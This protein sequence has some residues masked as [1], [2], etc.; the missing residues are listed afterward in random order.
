MRCFSFSRRLL[1][2]SSSSSSS[3]GYTLWINSYSRLVRRLHFL[4]IRNSLTTINAE[5]MEVG[6]LQDYHKKL[7]TSKDCKALAKKHFSADLVEKYKDTKTASGAT[8]QHCIKSCVENLD[9]GTGIYA[10]DAEC[11]DTF[12]DLFQRVIKD[13]H[14]VEADEISH[15]APDF[16][17]I[18]NLPFGDLDPDNEYVVSTRVRVGRSID[19]L[20]YPPM[21]SSEERLSIEDN[22]KKTLEDLPPE[23]AGTYYPLTGMDKDT[24][25]KLTDDHFLFNDH[26]RFLRSAGGYRDW[27]S[28]RGI[29]HNSDKTFLVWCN[30]EDHMRIISMQQGGNLAEVYNRLVKG[31]RSLETNMKFAHHDKY[32]YLTFCPTN[33]GTT[34]RASVHV[35]LPLL[36]SKPDFKET[37]EKMNL[38]PR[39]I[40]GEHTESVGGVYD[41]S[42]KRRLGLTEIDAVKEMA[43][44]V[45]KLIE[46]E[47][48][49]R[50][51]VEY[52]AK[53][54]SAVKDCK[55]LM[56]KYLKNNPT[57][58]K[59]TKTSLNGT[60]A[61]CIRSGVENPDSSV[62]IYACDP[63][64]YATFPEMF[65][66]VIKDYHKVHGELTHPKADFG[67]LENL[68]FGDVDPEGKFVISTRVRCGR[69]ITGYAFPPVIPKE[70]LAELEGKITGALNNLED[71]LKGTYFPL[72]AMTPEQQK[73]LTEDHFL[74]N[75]HD[76]FLRSAGGYRNWPMGRGIYHNDAK[77]FLVWCNE[78]DHMRIISMQKGGNLAEVYKRFATAV[79]KL[80]KELTFAH[81]DNLGYLTFCPT[82]LGTSLRASVHV[83][84]PGVSA[85]S[86]FKDICAKYNLQ[87][88]GIHGEH[89]ESVGGVFDISNKRRL[90][91]TEIDAVKEMAEGLAEIIKL[92]K[93]MGSELKQAQKKLQANKKCHSLLKK[94]LTPEVVEK[95]DE[96]KTSL[97]GTLYDSIKSGVENPESSV[98]IYACDPEAY[99]TFEDIFNPVIKD[100][101]K[102]EGEISHPTPDLGN[103]DELG[104]DDLDPDNSQV[105][106]T[107]VRVGRSL[108][109]YPF[110]PCIT[111]EQRLEIESKVKAALESLTDDL[112]GTYHSL[113]GMDKETQ[114][115][116]VEDHFLFN[117][118]DRFLRSAGGYRDWPSGRGI[119]FNE[120]KTFLVWCNEEDHMRII[121]MQKGGNLAEVYK[122]LVRAIHHLEKTLTFAKA[123][124]LGY[125]TFCPTNLG[126]TLR[127]SVHAKVPN[128]AAASKE[129]K[130]LCEQHHIQAR[131][132][133]GEHT[134]SV[135][136]VYDLS[137][138]RRLG[139]SEIDAVREMAAGVKAILETEKT[140]K[141][142]SL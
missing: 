125:L 100:Y 88:R 47:K 56:K 6:T 93:E 114:D 27:P 81:S 99:S 129:F 37:C 126:T 95:Y 19:Q 41:I 89:T 21:I 42:N 112:K 46:M 9:S 117:D 82:N 64:A 119:F 30:E 77:T 74:F 113:E 17:D 44:G 23:L 123:D 29:F 87:A 106:S 5:R 63:E 137:N 2:N 134:E 103:L 33:L 105:V 132:I 109:G 28:G 53:K 96:V 3:S 49:L 76:R 138:K 48:A 108:E 57:K 78:E 139:L 92:E 120:A 22:L 75:D 13:Y 62:G 79:Q 72:N 61:A 55:S 10:A 59:D 7:S 36:A 102:V 80:D 20:P 68:P 90:G 110:P 116:L 31:I 111:T 11:Y 35:R 121:S 25:Q 140:T 12:G 130:P 43:E 54:I 128:L 142:P 84:I 127:A 58:Y 107:R 135:G 115:K 8:L 71:E 83:R 124:K 94:H 26:D 97:G 38:Q 141:P 34:L 69:S 18:D 40:H 73:Q 136:G 16:G 24:Q 1:P 39:G 4:L 131:G 122:R 15:P 14:K 70:N 118:H 60:L 101:H 66:P 65:D 133:H 52:M 91:L 104:F 32:G 98:G 86:D 85:R 67:D 51:D 50:D 45:V